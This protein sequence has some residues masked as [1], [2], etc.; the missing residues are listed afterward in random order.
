MFKC[1]NKVI[2]RAA[3]DLRL[4]NHVLLAALNLVKNHYLSYYAGAFA[5]VDNGFSPRIVSLRGVVMAS[6]LE[7]LVLFQTL[8]VR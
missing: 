4:T 8:G 3:G 1:M 2:S 5:M 6:P 7:A